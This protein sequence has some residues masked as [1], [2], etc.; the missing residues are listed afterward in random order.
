MW[1]FYSHIKER[2][3]WQRKAFLTAERS[4]SHFQRTK[5][6]L[7]AVNRS[8]T[9]AHMDIDRQADAQVCSPTD[10]HT[11]ANSQWFREIAYNKPALTPT[12]YQL[13]IK[14]SPPTVS[15]P[16]H[17]PRFFNSKSRNSNQLTCQW[18]G[19]GVGW[20]W[21][22]HSMLIKPYSAVF[23]LCSLMFL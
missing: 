10:T 2:G 17:I 4:G 15:L 13:N 6:R 3:I 19:G 1:Q 16:K 11:N 7:L 18:R 9:D 20:G 12:L 8:Q 14:Y 22:N 5:T 23:S 21:W